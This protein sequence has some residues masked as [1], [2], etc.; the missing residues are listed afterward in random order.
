MDEIEVLERTIRKSD[1][2]FVLKIKDKNGKTIIREFYDD[3]PSEEKKEPSPIG[4]RI[5]TSINPGYSQPGYMPASD[6]QRGYSSVN[7]IRQQRAA[8]HGQDQ[9]QPAQN[10]YVPVEPNPAPRRLPTSG[11]YAATTP[12][13][14]QDSRQSKSKSSTR[15]S[16][17]TGPL[18]TLPRMSMPKSRGRK[19]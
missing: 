7:I 17:R 4:D 8:A 14:A 15:Q 6:Q 2:A 19:R 18:P 12:R 16:S 3:V 1:G 10:R 5:E 13:A 11:I 9:V